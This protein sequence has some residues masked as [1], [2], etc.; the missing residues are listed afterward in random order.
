M[1]N[2]ILEDY[3]FS[4]FVSKMRTINLAEYTTLLMIVEVFSLSLSKNFP[5]I[6]L[7]MRT[8]DWH[9]LQHLM[10]NR[11]W[12]FSNSWTTVTKSQV[13]TFLTELMSIIMATVS[14]LLFSRKSR[15]VLAIE[16]LQTFNGIFEKVRFETVSSRHFVKIWLWP[17]LAFVN[18]SVNSVFRKVLSRS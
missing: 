9:V 15:N 2:D 1:V 14:I 6:S 11:V 5:T 4:A 16:T 13:F 10:N 18:N 3:F 7:V 8:I 12:I 17:L